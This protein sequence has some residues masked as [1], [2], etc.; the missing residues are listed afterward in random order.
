MQLS[1]FLLHSLV[2]AKACSAAMLKS[3][4]APLSTIS[5]AIPSEG[6][7]FT[8]TLK[9][10]GTVPGAV[11]EGVPTGIFEPG[12]QT[13]FLPPQASETTTTFINEVYNRESIY[14]Q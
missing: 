3:S 8:S 13:I 1:H 9:A 6:K 5:I 4:A 7:A 14:I 2:V 10:C 12:T 11:I